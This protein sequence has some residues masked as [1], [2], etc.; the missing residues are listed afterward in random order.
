MLFRIGADESIFQ[1]KIKLS[2][3]FYAT[4]YIEDLYN[5]SIPIFLQ[6]P[7][8]FWFAFS[9]DLRLLGVVVDFK[10][11]SSIDLDGEREL[12]SIEVHQIHYFRRRYVVGSDSIQLQQPN[13]R[14]D[15][16]SHQPTIASSSHDDKLSMYNSSFSNYPSSRPLSSSL[17]PP[18]IL[19]QPETEIILLLSEWKGL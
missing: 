2:L 18:Y 17:P 16:K 4:C 7:F 6:L 13:H 15:P 1:M 19:K 12:I 3:E 9:C 8:Y 5:I 11:F 14:I 10:S